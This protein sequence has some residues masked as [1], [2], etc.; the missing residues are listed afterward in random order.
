MVSVSSTRY[1]MLAF[2][3]Y[4]NRAYLFENYDGTIREWMEMPIGLG[5][6]GGLS[7]NRRFSF[8]MNSMEHA[9]VYIGNSQF[10]IY[11]YDGTIYNSTLPSGFSLS[12]TN[13]YLSITRDNDT[14]FITHVLVMS[15]I[16]T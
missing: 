1:H 11:L 8:P 3:Q 13:G 2:D 9:Q 5:C 16:S 12:Y 4:A 14:I 7:E 15:N 6:F 10:M